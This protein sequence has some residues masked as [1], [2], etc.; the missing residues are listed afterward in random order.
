MKRFSRKREAIYK[1]LCSTDSHPSAEWVYEKLKP[2]YP[3]LS[4]ATVYRN[5]AGF[6]EEG[7][8]VRLVSVDGQERYDAKTKPHGHFI[9]T[10]CGAVLDLNDA[11]ENEIS[12]DRFAE[13][14]GAEIDR[15]ELFLYGRC[16]Q[17]ISASEDA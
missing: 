12:Y 4:L 6:A 11:E 14:L 9:C 3:D 7:R 2:E 10:Q 1:L 5:L 15:H 8:I 13:S 16:R 17:C